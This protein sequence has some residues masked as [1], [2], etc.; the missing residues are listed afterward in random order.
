MYIRLATLQDLEVLV[1]LFDGYRVFYRQSSDYDK[2]HSFLKERLINKDS[3][4]YIAFA[5]ADSEIAVGFTQL[6]PIFSSVSMERMYILNDLYIHSD[7]RNLGIG[8]ALINEVKNLCRKE[9]Q[10]GIV[11]QTETTN[12]AQHL[13][14]RLGFT[15]DPDLHYFWP[16]N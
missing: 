2:A 1:P 12:P 13:Y 3:V 6:Y 11:I 15:K 5:K 14:E 4:I 7:Y 10:K 9:H 8:Q 16:T